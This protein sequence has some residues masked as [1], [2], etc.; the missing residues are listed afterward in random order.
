VVVTKRDVINLMLI[1]I[2]LL[3]FASAT[4]A[5][6][7][8]YSKGPYNTVVAVDTIYLDSTETEYTTMY[9]QDNGGAKSLVL[10][11]F[12]DS[13]AGFASDSAAASIELLQG[14]GLGDDKHVAL[15]PSRA[16]PDSTTW[17]YGGDF[18]IDDSLDVADMCTTCVWQRVATPKTLFGD[19][20][21][22]DYTQDVSSTVST[23]GAMYYLPITPDFSPFMVLKLTGK[24]SNLKRG[25]GSRWIVRWVQEG[26]LK[27]KR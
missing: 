2:A 22:W 1:S 5:A 3:L 4:G 27:T 17:P 23:F 6:P 25:S 7:A 13:T 26:G 8:P 15:M 24:A 9:L 12:D 14:F 11:V 16:H 10:E 21:D 20:V 19:T 18:V